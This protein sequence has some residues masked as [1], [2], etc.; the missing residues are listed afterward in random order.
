MNFDFYF[1]KLQERYNLSMY[2]PKNNKN[3]KKALELINDTESKLELISKSNFKEFN[4]DIFI[5]TLKILPFND[6]PVFFG[7]EVF[8][9]SLFFFKYYNFDFGSK[10]N[11]DY[12]F[13]LNSSL[14]FVKGALY[15]NM[16]CIAN[17]NGKTFNFNNIENILNFRFNVENLKFTV[18]DL[19]AIIKPVKHGI[20]LKYYCEIK[21]VNDKM[22]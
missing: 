19:Y 15:N 18:E 1:N 11:K 17:Q 14:K 7:L 16:D 13:L 21:A 12:L 10:I 3:E 20:E 9:Q 5:D 8:N 6:T 22:L 2:K 4:D